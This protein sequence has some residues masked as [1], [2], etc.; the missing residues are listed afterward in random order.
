MIAERQHIAAPA[1]ECESCRRTNLSLQRRARNW[2]RVTPAIPS[3]V[4]EVLSEKGQP[5]DAQTRSEM[6]PRFGHNF[7]KVRIHCGA[8]SEKSAQDLNAHAYSAG[9]DIVFGAGRFAPAT[10]EGRQ[11]IAHEL[12]HVVQQRGSAVEPQASVSQAGDAWERDADRM[13]IQALGSGNGPI[14][15]RT[16]MAS[17]PALMR[18]PDDQKEKLKPFRIPGTPLLAIPLEPARG[19]EAITL[20]G[21]RLPYRAVRITNEENITPLG[22]IPP[23]L[24]DPSGFLRGENAPPGQPAA[25]LPRFSITAR[26]DR[27]AIDITGRIPLSLRPDVVPGTP[28]G[29]KAD[30]G[31][32]KRDYLVNP[33]IAVGKRLFATGTLSL[34]DQYPSHY[35][36]PTEIELTATSDY[37]KTITPKEQGDR[38][39]FGQV[40]KVRANALKIGAAKGDISMF[41]DLARVD[42]ALAPLGLNRTE[43]RALRQEIVAMIKAKVAELTKNPN[44]G[45]LI[46]AL[47]T[48]NPKGDFAKALRQTIEARIPPDTRPSVVDSAIESVLKEVSGPGFSIQG[49]IF[50]GIPIGYGYFRAETT[51][52]TRAPLEGSGIGT[53]FPSTLATVGPTLIPKGVI[54]DYTAPAGGATLARDWQSLALS[55]TIAAKP[56]LEPGSIGVAGVAAGRLGFR[57]KGFDVVLEGGWRGRAALTGKTSSV[58]GDPVARDFARIGEARQQAGARFV[59]EAEGAESGIFRPDLQPAEVLSSDRPPA[60]FFGSFHITRRF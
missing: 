57:L 17:P 45:T 10:Q 4:R 18:Q 1:G 58:G 37:F 43:A 12:A 21:I 5:L 27:V 38:L 26:A 54:T 16:N 11:L 49:P 48:F 8:T 13:A 19:G 29:G 3:I 51:R 52:R 44:L 59:E 20:F 36:A 23:D 9:N 33:S 31:N 15:P 35:T 2:D 6:E 28:L 55:A 40:G 39:D 22:A 42:A 56:S 60:E 34:H 32:V 47:S 14:M 46:D 24:S 25:S 50:F 7:G 30:E 41:L 53:P